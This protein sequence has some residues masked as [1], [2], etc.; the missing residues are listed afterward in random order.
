MA[1]VFLRVQHLNHGGGVVG[2]FNPLQPR[3]AFRA[4]DP[5][6]ITYG[7]ALSNPQVTRDAFAPKR[8]D[9]RLQVSDTGANWRTIMGGIHWNVG[10]E[11]E[12]GVVNVQGH[13]WMEYLNQP[14]WFAPYEFDGT[15]LIAGPSGKSR[16]QELLDDPESWA[17]VWI[18]V[19]GTNTE[20]ITYNATQQIVVQEMI[21]G[22]ANG[23][24]NTLNMNVA[25][26]GDG[27]GWT[28]VMNYLIMF[29]D[30]TTVLDHIRA[31]SNL[32]DPYGFD[33]F[34]N[35]D[36]TLVC[37]NPTRTAP[38]AS[39]NSI[40]TIRRN[41]SLVKLSWEN[42][43]PLATYTVGLG[44]GN[45]GLW[46][47]KTYAPS[48]QA[49]RRWLRLARLGEV[50]SGTYAKNAARM[51]ETIEAATDGLPDRFPQKELKI[52]IKPDEI[53]PADPTAFFHPLIGEALY[54][55]V[56]FPPY[57]RINANFWIIAQEFYTDDEGNWLCDVS[58][59]Q[60]YDPSGIG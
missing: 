15:E 9:F 19:G 58:L 57:H 38:I 5:G 29:Q 56:D 39:I 10:L 8:T 13:D 37:Y 45:P 32:A 12:T 28:E 3:F 23:E 11:N 59:D 44:A 16:L 55:D 6:D 31:I 17:R 46:A 47:T 26:S 36:K 27:T 4:N 22:I 34:M 51:A 20:L 1:R 7:L 24:D 54:V 21:D 35:W 50:Y 40:Y 42:K 41:S 18:G 14:Y 48:N 53:E 2:T 49:Y 52:T 33:F 60:I 43:G 25:F 30:E